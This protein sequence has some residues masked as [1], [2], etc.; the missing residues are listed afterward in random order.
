MTLEEAKIIA[1]VLECADGGC[2]QCASELA[3]EMSAVF[4]AFLWHLE[5]GKSIAEW[6]IQVKAR[7]DA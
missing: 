7:S 4:P 6:S 3:D 1:G 5:R 2:S